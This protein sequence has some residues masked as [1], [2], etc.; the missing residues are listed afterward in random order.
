MT[1]KL[2]YQKKNKKKKT[3][4]CTSCHVLYGPLSKKCPLLIVCA[5]K[6]LVSCT[7]GFL[8]DTIDHYLKAC[9]GK[10]DCTEMKMNW[11]ISMSEPSG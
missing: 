8:K 9:A 10:H 6:M 3:N 11:V 7:A 5:A 2:N 4:R 1:K